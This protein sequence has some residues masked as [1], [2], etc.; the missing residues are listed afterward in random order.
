MASRSRPTLGECRPRNL[1]NPFP[2]AQARRTC[3]SAGSLYT[4]ATHSHTHQHPGQCLSSTCTTHNVAVGQ[5]SRLVDAR[6]EAAKRRAVFV[7]GS[8]RGRTGMAPGHRSPIDAASS[9][10]HR[11][12]AV[13]SANRRGPH[14]LQGGGGCPGCAEVS[15]ARRRR[16]PPIVAPQTQ[17]RPSREAVPTS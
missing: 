2:W 3:A 7:V 1:L 11:G 16:A 4:R 10:V 17:Q 12:L 13:P 15:G 9:G 8:T 5:P 6:Q 14:I